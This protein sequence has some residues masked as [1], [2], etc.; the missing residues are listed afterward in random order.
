M[1]Y[2]IIALLCVLPS[3]TFANTPSDESVIQFMEIQKTREHVV[4]LLSASLA[5][6]MMVVQVFPF[7]SSDKDTKMDVE[8]RWREILEIDK[9]AQEKFKHDFK[10]HPKFMALIDEFHIQPIFQHYKENF[11]QDEINAMIDF[12]QTPIGQSIIQKEFMFEYKKI[13][14]ESGFNQIAYYVENYDNRGEI[15]S[16]ISDTEKMGEILEEAYL[17]SLGIQYIS[18]E[19]FRLAEEQ[20]KNAK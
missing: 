16:Y 17:E 11:T 18:S 5:H 6:S 9:V 1:R 10:T 20:N 12:Y 2:F 19:M 13:H 15:Q 4:D 14:E 7:L 3:I 8:N